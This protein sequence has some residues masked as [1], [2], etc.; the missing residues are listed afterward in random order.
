MARARRALPSGVLVARSHPSS[1][2]RPASLNSTVTA[3]FRP[4]IAASAL[5]RTCRPPGTRPA[6]LPFPYPT[7]VD[8]Y[9]DMVQPRREST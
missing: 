1:V 3:G 5:S 7:C 2:R 8:V 6:M 9:F 4:R